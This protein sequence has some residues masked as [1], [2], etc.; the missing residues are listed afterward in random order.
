M[1]KSKFGMARRSPATK[2]FFIFPGRDAILRH[3]L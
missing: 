2:L 3:N 1:A